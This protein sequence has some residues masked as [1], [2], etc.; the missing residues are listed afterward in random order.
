MTTS[1]PPPVGP[2]GET[3]RDT[4][5]ET[6][7]PFAAVAI[8]IVLVVGA[9]WALVTLR[10]W[11]EHG[12]SSPYALEVPLQ[13]GHRL[14]VY[15]EGFGDIATFV[16]VLD[17]RQRL[18]TGA[19]LGYDAPHRP[20]AIRIDGRRVTIGTNHRGPE[21]DPVWTGEAPV[22]LGRVELDLDQHDWRR[23]DVDRYHRLRPLIAD[24]R[25]SAAASDHRPPA[26]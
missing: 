6:W 21:I 23:L 2:T 3:S 1:D 7:K 19:S 25:A 17:G 16:M 20:S 9:G 11:V 4:G 22:D 10:D 13:R 14:L 15:H 24:L 8:I 18:V 26:E 5:G 12:L